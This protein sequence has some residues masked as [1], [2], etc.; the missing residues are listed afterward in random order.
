MTAFVCAEH[1]WIVPPDCTGCERDRAGNGTVIIAW[2][3]DA[4][5]H[6]ERWAAIFRA[7]EMV[8]L[9]TPNMEAA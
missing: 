5:G 8:R 6:I 7:N 4:C 2:T 3:C 9:N 1:V